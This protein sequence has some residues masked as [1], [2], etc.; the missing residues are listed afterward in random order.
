MKRLL[1]ALVL[2]L[3]ACASGPDRGSTIEEEDATWFWLETPDGR[4][5]ECVWVA[6]NSQSEW[7]MAGMDCD[8]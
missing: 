5:I 3:S 2:V 4:R 6:V 7:A 1:L 8:W